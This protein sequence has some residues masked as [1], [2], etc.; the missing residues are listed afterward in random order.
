MTRLIGIE[1]PMPSLPPEL[2][3]TAVTR[4]DRRIGLKE[5]LN[6]DRLVTKFEIATTFGA[7]DAIRNTV[8]QAEGAADGKNEIADLDLFAVANPRRHRVLTGDRQ[9][10]DVG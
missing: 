4:I 2:L 1:K 7:D 9:D 10:S 5:V 8:S 3:A 6:F